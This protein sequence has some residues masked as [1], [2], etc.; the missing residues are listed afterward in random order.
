MQSILLLLLLLNPLAYAESDNLILSSNDLDIIVT[1]EPIEIKP[2]ELVTFNLTFMKNS[3]N[4][5]TNY[6]FIVLKDDIII[7]EVRN[8]FTIDGE[9]THIV[10]FPSSGSFTLI[11]NILDN[12]DSVTF[13]LKVT[14]E[15]PIGMMIVVITLI[16]ITIVLTRLSIMNKNKHLNSSNL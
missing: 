15:F 13:D 16:G 5:N 3:T 4:T 8:A 2:N 12:E 1:W 9:A 11:I 14:P 6:D 10:E 7:K